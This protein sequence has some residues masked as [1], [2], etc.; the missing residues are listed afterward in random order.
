M[1]PPMRSTICHN[2][3][4]N[5]PFET[6]VK[7]RLYCTVSCRSAVKRR[8]ERQRDLGMKPPEGD[9]RTKII[10]NPTPEGLQAAVVA[11][12]HSHFDTF[13]FQGVMPMWTP[14][15]DF[16]LERLFASEEPQWELILKSVHAAR[17]EL[18]MRKMNASAP[19]M[20]S[21]LSTLAPSLVQATAEP[22]TDLDFDPQTDLA[23]PVPEREISAEQRRKD[24]LG[25]L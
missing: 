15:D 12:R 6:S 16:Q 22:I 14:P 21:A 10:T 17:V 19:V 25:D 8:R 11:L 4:C 9:A 18:V 13:I 3:N 5:R 23:P 7:G 20:P 2:P 1:L 24:A